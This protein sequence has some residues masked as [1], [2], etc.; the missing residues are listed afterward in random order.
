MH[1]YE[2]KSYKTI[3]P[4]GPKWTHEKTNIEHLNIKTYCN[5]YEYFNET[6]INDMYETE[7]KKNDK[8]ITTEQ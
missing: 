2:L 6:T 5:Y 4:E 1:R 3:R 8:T 7:Q